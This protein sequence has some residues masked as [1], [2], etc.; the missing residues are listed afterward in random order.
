MVLKVMERFSTLLLVRKLNENDI[1]LPFSSLRLAR[2]QK[3]GNTLFQGLGETDTVMPFSWGS[4]GVWFEGTCG[5]TML[6]PFDSL[7]VLLGIYA[8][9]TCVCVE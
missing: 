7:L 9:D 5:N 2:H 1:E 8:T 3:F 4:E 6:T